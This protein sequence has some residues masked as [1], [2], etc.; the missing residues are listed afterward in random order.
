LGRPPQPDEATIALRLIASP[1]TEV[2]VQ[3]L[4]WAILLLPEFQLIY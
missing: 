2:G 4:L 1:A 3:D